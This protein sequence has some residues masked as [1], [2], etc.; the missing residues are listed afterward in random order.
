[1]NGIT[2]LQYLRL[3][4]SAVSDLLFE[5]FNKPSRCT[6]WIDPKSQNRQSFQRAYLYS[7]PYYLMASI[8]FTSTTLATEYL[9]TRPSND[10]A[11]RGII[12]LQRVDCIFF[13]NKPLYPFLFMRRKYTFD[14]SWPIIEGRTVIRIVITNGIDLYFARVRTASPLPRPFPNRPITTDCIPLPLLKSFNQLHWICKNILI[15]NLFMDC[16]SRPL[17]F[18]CRPLRHRNMYEG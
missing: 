7:R 2:S 13:I 12:S 1:M 4:S 9:I 16:R 3:N 11:T 15:S 14:V 6:P 10:N 18:H 17:Y 5:V 8:N